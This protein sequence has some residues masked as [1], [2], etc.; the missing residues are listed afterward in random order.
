MAIF[1]YSEFLPEIYCVEIVEEIPEQL[2]CLNFERISKGSISIFLFKMGDQT[3]GA[4]QPLHELIIKI[5]IS[6]KL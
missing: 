2:V 3:I 1:I 6:R 4:W 5:C